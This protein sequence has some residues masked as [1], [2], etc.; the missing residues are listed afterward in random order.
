MNHPLF[1]SDRF[2]PIARTLGWR[3]IAI[4][5]ETGE[6]EIGFDGKPEFRNPAGYIQGGILT[7]M[8]DDSM[9]P[10][11]LVASKGEAYTSSIDIHTH[12]LKPVRPGPITTRARVTRM[13]KRIAFLEAQ[14]FDANGDLCAR[15][16]S[17]AMLQPMPKT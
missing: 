12:F 15:A 6:I 17:S 13:G 5:D 16:T 10:A 11:G 1:D 3:L 4:D 2:P 14:L 7:A 9:G 8:L